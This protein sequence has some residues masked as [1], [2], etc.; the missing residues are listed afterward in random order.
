MTSLPTLGL[1]SAHFGK[2]MQ[3]A[4]GAPTEEE[5]ERNT[6]CETEKL[7]FLT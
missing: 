6:K 1:F 2:S 5:K 3:T 7:C 4:L